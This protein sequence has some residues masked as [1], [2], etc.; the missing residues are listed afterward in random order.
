VFQTKNF[1]ESKDSNY[2]ETYFKCNDYD[3]Q[4][5]KPFFHIKVSKSMQL[6]NCSYQKN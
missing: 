2:P 1:K 5:T 6:N 4:N 3:H